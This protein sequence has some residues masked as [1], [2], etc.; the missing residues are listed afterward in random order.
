[1]RSLAHPWPI[2]QNWN[3][4]FSLC[5]IRCR[6]NRCQQA[7]LLIS[8]QCSSEIIAHLDPFHSLYHQLP[9]C[10]SQ[11][12]QSRYQDSPPRHGNLNQDGSILPASSPCLWNAWLVT[13]LIWLSEGS[14]PA[15]S[16]TETLG[17]GVFLKKI[18]N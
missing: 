6:V 17:L 11:P 2:S 15:S 14:A 9:A 10:T 13:P 7:R 8:I 3:V 1:M 18:I 12:P 16:D 4:T 5:T